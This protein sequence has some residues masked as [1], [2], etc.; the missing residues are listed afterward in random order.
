VLR[1]IMLDHGGDRCTGLWRLG[2][3]AE[4]FQWRCSGCERV[5]P[6]TVATALRVAWERRVAAAMEELT[7]EGQRI[8]DRVS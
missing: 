3:R 5:Y 7:Q 6:A 2:S 4:G 8:R 1:E